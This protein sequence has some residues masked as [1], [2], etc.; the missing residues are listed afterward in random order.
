MVIE[1]E[2]VEWNFGRLSDYIKLNL[3]KEDGEIIELEWELKSDPT[4]MGLS[5]SLSDE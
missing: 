1:E 4:D 3:V 2:P 5:I